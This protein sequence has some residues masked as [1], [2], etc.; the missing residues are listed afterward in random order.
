MQTESEA[1]ATRQQMCDPLARMCLCVCRGRQ[2]VS[3]RA[4]ETIGSGGGREKET[5]M[6]AL[7]AHLCSSREF[8]LWLIVR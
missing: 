8:A 5:M 7:S 2:R 6:K 1:A 4:K 3:T